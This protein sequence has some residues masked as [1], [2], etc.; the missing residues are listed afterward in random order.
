MEKIW[1]K[2]YPEGVP[3]DINPD[4][5]QSLVQILNESC[6]KFGDLPAFYN[7]GKTISYKEFDLYSQAFASYL[8]HQLKLNK[9]DRLALML[10]N[11]LQYPI[12]MYGAMRAGIIVVNVNPLYTAPEL[13]HQLKDSGA[14]A[15]LVL[16]NFAATVE[17]AIPGTS[18]KHVIITD[19]GDMLPLPK[20][21]LIKF[22]LKYIQKKIPV[23]KIPNAI[24]FKQILTRGK[25]QA[26]VPQSISNQDIA[27]LQYTGGTTGISKGAMLT[28]RNII[29]NIL[30]A[31]EWF[32]SLLQEGKEIIITAL[33][34][35]H[36]FSLTANCLFFS[37]MGGLN[38][39]ITNPRDLPKMISD[40]RKFKFTA[41]TGVNTL[42]NGLLKHP[43]FQTL[44]FSYLKM[45]LGGGMAVQRV[46]AEKW[47]HVTG[48]PLME[49][50][51]LTETSPCVAMNPVNMKQY[52]GT[53]GLP[54]SST[55]VTLLDDDGHEVPI[56]HP[57][58]LAVKGPQVMKGYWNNPSETAKVFTPDGWL[59][60]GDIASMD[61]KGFIRILERKKDMILVSG[62]NVYPNEIE[63]ALVTIP[64]I[65]EAAVVGVPDENSGEAVKALL[66]KDDESVTVNDV[67]EFCKKMLTGYKIPKY[68][69]F[70]QELPKS[71]VGKILRRSLRKESA[72]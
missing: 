16:S 3:A 35:Y 38:V 63:D 64:G 13:A 61:E 65:V 27:F 55:N 1:L 8:Q 52:S 60:T 70:R 37:R 31:H 47:Q 49:A 58:E 18:V 26:F 48:T 50:Y 39:L 36:I 56:G 46:V 54:V 41:F 15:I 51:G 30:Q 43:E 69:E 17:K 6:T 28:H 40:M 44:D 45:S 10:P 20:A 24:T 34:L 68:V 5:Y 19:V 59:L 4:E 7:L 21:L 11:L 71:N 33:P 62:F 2:S 23:W 9:G 53:V 32:A 72:N 67:M 42:F 14:N 66:V 22:V 25:E 57:G 29:S 12:A